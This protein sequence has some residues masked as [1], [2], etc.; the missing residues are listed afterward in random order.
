MATVRVADD[1][2]AAYK[3]LAGAEPGGPSV[4]A[5][6]DA[7]LRRDLGLNMP[8][9]TPPPGT[10]KRTPKASKAV[11][12][13]ASPQLKRSAKADT[14]PVTKCVVHPPGRIIDGVCM[15]CGGKV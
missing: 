1:V 7:A 9:G 11:T 3:K 14:G 15:K 5:R 6:I 2:N 12:K 8:D 13:S 4:T 10:P